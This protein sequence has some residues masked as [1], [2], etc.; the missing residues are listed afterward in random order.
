MQMKQPLREQF[1]NILERYDPSFAYMQTPL[2]NNVFNVLGIQSNEVLICRFLGYLLTPNAGHGLGIV[3]LQNFLK[4]IHFPYAPDPASLCSAIVELE[5][6]T[7]AQ[8]RVDIAIYIADY[9]IPIEVK[10]YA[11]DQRSQ[12]YDYYHYYQDGKKTKISGMYYLTPNGRKPSQESIT[13]KDGHELSNEQYHCIS[14][15][16]TIQCWLDTLPVSSD[17]NRLIAQFKEVIC[18][19]NNEYRVT[20][21]LLEVL[22]LSEDQISPCPE[23]IASILKH[24]DIIWER[25]RLQYLKHCIDIGSLKNQYYV[26]DFDGSDDK[27]SHCLLVIKQIS[28]GKTVAWICVDKNLYIVIDHEPKSPQWKYP[29]EGYAWRY[30]SPAG[31][32][33][34]YDLRTP[35]PAIHSDD[36][37]H[38]EQILKNE[39]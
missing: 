38:L 30:L 2:N 28:D 15:H 31:T 9:I 7:D 12:L 10:I 37:I 27:D 1:N 18:A 11:P 39:L 34:T 22:G 36:V 32:D 13:S 29:Q 17:Q 16:T 24:S 6:H 20:K 14:F 35:N 4:A 8:R 23:L 33:G 5:D 3:P 21:E 26:T 25:L 19:M